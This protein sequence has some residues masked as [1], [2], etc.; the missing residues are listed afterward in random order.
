MKTQACRRTLRGHTG[1]VS[2]VALIGGGQKDIEATYATSTNSS[3]L[4]ASTSWDSTIRLWRVGEAATAD[5]VAEIFDQEFRVMNSG[6]GNALY[7]SSVGEG[8]RTISVGGRHNHIQRWDVDREALVISLLGHAK[9]VQAL[10]TVGRII[11]S[12]SGDGTAKLWDTSTGSCDMTFRGH[13]DSVMT[14]QVRTETTHQVT[15]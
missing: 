8:G 9:E 3:G 4:L 10:D 14:V 13:T 6:Q 15:F 12:G 7:C 11:V 1:W 2:S 5:D